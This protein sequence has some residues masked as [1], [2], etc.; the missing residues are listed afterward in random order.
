MFAKIFNGWLGEKM[1]QFNFWLNLD[2]RPCIDAMFKVVHK[3]AETTPNFS[4]V[5]VSFVVSRPLFGPFFPSHL[6]E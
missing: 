6:L 1:V 2:D 5:V 4:K 3:H